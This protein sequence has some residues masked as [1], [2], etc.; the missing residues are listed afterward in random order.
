MAHTD[1]TF[2]AC[3]RK[4]EKKYHYKFWVCTIGQKIVPKFTFCSQLTLKSWELLH[5][6]KEVC[7]LIGG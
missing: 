2:A 7:M 4:R 5:E 6:E 1:D 3:G